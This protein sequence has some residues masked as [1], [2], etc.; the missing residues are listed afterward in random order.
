MTHVEAARRRA[1]ALTLWFQRVDIARA[2][3]FP[4]TNAVRAVVAE[5]RSRG[6]RRAVVRTSGRPRKMR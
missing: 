3:G 6:D 2:L 1:R 4:S 5:A